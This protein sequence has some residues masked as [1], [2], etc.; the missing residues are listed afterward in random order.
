MSLIDELAR[1]LLRQ[2]VD[3]D[4]DGSLD[5][6]ADHGIQAAGVAVCRDIAVAVESNTIFLTVSLLSSLNH[7]SFGGIL[8]PD[9]AHDTPS[10]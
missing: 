8:T 9:Q 4:S 5:L 6:G 3:V 10:A 2:A 1:P 7:D